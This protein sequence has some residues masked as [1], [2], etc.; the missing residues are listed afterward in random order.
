MKTDQTGVLELSEKALDEKTLV[1]PCWLNGVRVGPFEV[2]HSC[3]WGEV[4]VVPDI[5]SELFRILSHFSCL[6]TFDR[7]AGPDSRLA[8][9]CGRLRQSSHRDQ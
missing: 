9:W 3:G 2:I 4:N 8:D 7:L 6:V 5:P 1:L